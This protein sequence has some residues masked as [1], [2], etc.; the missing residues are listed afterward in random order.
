MSNKERRKFKEK[1]KRA[2]ENISKIFNPDNQFKRT[3][4]AILKSIFG[5]N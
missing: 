5:D 4:K 3:Q 2:N 1:E